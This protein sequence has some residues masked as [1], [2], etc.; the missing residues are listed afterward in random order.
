MNKNVDEVKNVLN[1]NNISYEII[2]DGNKIINQYPIGGNLINGKLLLFTNGNLTENNLGGLS[3]KQVNNYCKMVNIPCNIKGTGYVTNYSYQK[4]ES[5]KINL[6]NIEL[7][8][9]FKDVI[10]N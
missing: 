1:V 7:D 10:G 6:I 8:Q 9:K 2:G 4:D 5:G 3:S